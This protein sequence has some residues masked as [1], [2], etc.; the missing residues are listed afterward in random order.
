MSEFVK[1]Y[2]QIDFKC[3]K[4]EHNLKNKIKYMLFEQIK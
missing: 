2:G 3:V 1:Y 4:I